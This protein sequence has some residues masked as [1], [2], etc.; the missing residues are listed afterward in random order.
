MKKISL[1]LAFT[2]LG[3]AAASAQGLYIGPGGVGIDGG[4]PDR[5]ER[6]ERMER[7]GY[8][9]REDR[10]IVRDRRDIRSTGSVE[11]CRTTIV[12]R[13]NRFGELVTRRIRECD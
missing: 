13:E 5:V 3:S 1:L 7:R 2:V 9:P 10:V 11:R 6:I 4:R 12:R 8:G